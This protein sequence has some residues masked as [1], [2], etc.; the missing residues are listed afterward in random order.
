MMG[1]GKYVDNEYVFADKTFI[2]LEVVAVPKPERKVLH[3]ELDPEDKTPLET[4]EKLK[5]LLLLAERIDDIKNSVEL[6]GVM[7]VITSQFKPESILFHDKDFYVA[8]GKWV[9]GNVDDLACRYHSNEG[10]GYPNGMGNRQ[11][12]RLPVALKDVVV[13]NIESLMIQFKKSPL[14]VEVGQWIRTKDDSWH[15]ATYLYGNDEMVSAIGLGKSD[16]YPI[17]IKEI[18]EVAKAS[19]ALH[20]YHRGR[21]LLWHINGYVFLTFEGTGSWGQSVSPENGLYYK[22]FVHRKVD[23]KWAVG[24][25]V[26]LAY[27]YQLND[28]DLLMELDALPDSISEFMAPI[29]IQLLLNRARVKVRFPV[30]VDSVSDM[31]SYFGEESYHAYV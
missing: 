9:S 22:R 13:E 19:S 23:G 16:D 21:I 27:F 7:S 26:S 14:N 25:Q 11:W 8:S 1:I 10:L 30:D 29:D 18:V 2:D 12:M 20:K 3:V 24:E 5:P 6:K 17:L 4:I 28:C 31:D 15:L